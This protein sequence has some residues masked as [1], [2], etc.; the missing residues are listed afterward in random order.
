MKR[1]SLILSVI[2]LSSV[3]SVVD[4]QVLSSTDSQYDDEAAL[5][6]MTVAEAQELM[7]TQTWW[8]QTNH[9][10]F[11]V[12]FGY[13]G[14]PSAY[15][16]PQTIFIVPKLFATTKAGCY[17]NI[18]AIYNDYTS[19][20]DHFM[21]NI[22]GKI[23]LYSYFSGYPVW[24]DHPLFGGSA[25][26]RYYVNK[27]TLSGD[28][29]SKTMTLGNGNLRVRITTDVLAKL[30]AYGLQMKGYNVTFN[31]VSI[32]DPFAVFP[33]SG[34][35]AKLTVPVR[36]DYQSKKTS[37]N[38]GSEWWQNAIV[39]NKSLFTDAH[40]GDVLH[41]YTSKSPKDDTDGSPYTGYPTVGNEMAS[42][43]DNTSQVYFQCIKGTT[44]SPTSKSIDRGWD[45]MNTDAYFVLSDDDIKN[46][47]KDGNTTQ[48]IINGGTIRKVS[49]DPGW[50]DSLTFQINSQMKE[51]PHGTEYTDADDSGTGTSTSTS[52]EDTYAYRIYLEN[53]RSLQPHAGDII[54]LS[55]INS[56]GHKAAGDVPFVGVDYYGTNGSGS[57]KKNVTWSTR[58]ESDNA[59]RVLSKKAGLNHITTDFNGDTTLVKITLDDADIAAINNSDHSADDT[60][61]ATAK[62]DTYYW[63]AIRAMGMTI[64][65][66]Y[67]DKKIIPQHHIV[68]LSEDDATTCMRTE[69]DV[70]VH[71]KRKLTAGRWSTM[72]LPF[73]L[74]GG[75]IADVFGPHAI[76]ATMYE[77]TP[78]KDG[79]ETSGY[80]GKE[81]YC[82]GFQSDSKIYANQPFLVKIAEEDASYIKDPSKG[83]YYDFKNVNMQLKG[84]RN[85][86]DQ[87]YGNGYQMYKPLFM[88][89]TYSVIPQL[90]KYAI[91]LTT[92][93]NAHHDNKLMQDFYYVGDN[94][95]KNG[96]VKMKGY[97]WYMFFSDN[98]ENLTKDYY[99][100]YFTN[101]TKP[102]GLSKPNIMITVDGQ[103]INE[104]TTTDIKGVRSFENA[105]WRLQ[106]VYNVAG[107]QVASR[108][109]ERRLPAGIYVVGGRKVVIK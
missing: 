80:S 56:T 67:L 6:L 99:T 16:N 106:P 48:L 12:S 17:L 38:T 53:I 79:A 108:L 14:N 3:P 29:H 50:S 21:P 60:Y 44:A 94:T 82:I 8:W 26:I 43:A 20:S 15:N 57:S 27:N 85:G 100:T 4:A 69:P 19:A 49:I 81:Y 78:R 1:N 35:T 72:I 51:M 5:H 7:P 45:Y 34:S 93:A 107:Q 62:S 41:V 70:D 32:V 73:N 83:E 76:V 52:T 63:L 55:L 97:R 40:A 75:K 90:P 23:G 28:D 66:A 54:R 102:T 30:Q 92:K 101:D 31:S 11:P 96:G 84:G 24:S 9:P 104:T 36:R 109:G 25:D 59:K 91:Y 46:I 33:G 71:L 42:N 13:D 88:I 77:S 65:G 103:D 74:E 98:T 105:E 95:I 10:S 64:N 87:N 2:L 89:G 86:G 68:N 61:S 37:S 58:G 18:N 22:C 47:K 39:L